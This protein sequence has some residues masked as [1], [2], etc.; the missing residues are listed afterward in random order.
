MK[1]SKICDS[2]TPDK[3]H[4]SIEQHLCIVCGIA[5]DTD[6]ILLDTRLKA[7]MEPHTLTDW[8]FC[9]THQKLQDD[10]YIALIGID[11]TRSGKP[12]TP[13]TVHRIGSIAHLKRAVWEEVVDVPV[14]ES[15]ICFC[16]AELIDELEKIPQI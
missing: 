8:G 6:A 13:D 4:V 7:S 2:A 3:S 14:P 16:N 12:L 9:E 10:G 1:N 11:E 5:F 15:S